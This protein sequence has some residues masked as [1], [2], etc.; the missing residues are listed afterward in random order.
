MIRRAGIVFATC[1]LVGLGC[2]E[3]KPDSWSPTLRSSLIGAEEMRVRTGGTC[4]RQPT[5]EVELY[6]TSDRAEIDS[7]LNLIE[8]DDAS[9]ETT[10]ACCGKPT[11]EFYKGGKLY[12]TL[13]IQHGK[14]L[15]WIDGPW[16]GDG[17]LT[18]GSARQFGEWLET[19]G[20]SGPEADR[21]QSE[22][23]AEQARKSE[24][25]W[26][27]AMPPSLRSFWRNDDI[28]GPS[29]EVLAEMSEALQKSIPDT[30]PRVRAL[31]AWYGSG[32]VWNGYPDYERVPSLLLDQ[33]STSKIV[34]AI[35]GPELS[36]AELD[37]AAR[38][39]CDKS[40]RLEQLSPRLKKKLLDYCVA[41]G[42]EEK[43][44]WGQDAFGK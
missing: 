13:G 30:K 17:S 15:R 5:Q 26:L 6:R 2:R 39:F 9:S 29:K 37:G 31:L 32:E 11:I 7:L 16:E 36:E 41:S 27:A 35:D 43:Q 8:I 38:L 4:H 18:S 12:L 28:D 34:D 21:K 40:E 22:A 23:A 42:S 20:V 44:E 1:L 3:S 33:Y 19:R 24:E 25:K 10:C 14:A